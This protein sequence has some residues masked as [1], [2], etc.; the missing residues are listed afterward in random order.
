MARYL[1][2]ACR[3]CRREGLKLFLKGQRCYTEKCAIE[4]RQYAPGQHGQNRVKHSEYGTQLR[5]KQKVKR[6]YGLLERQFRGFFHKAEREK[7]ITGEELLLRLER[8]L[9]N[10]VYR[11]GFCGSR[12]E[13]RQFVLHGHFL[14]N[15]KKVTIPSYLAKA[16]DRIAVREKSRAIPRILESLEEI[17]RRGLPAWLELDRKNF[18]GT[19]KTLPAREELTFPVQEQLIVELYSK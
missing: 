15:D 11:I 17:E 2:S 19:I 5:E 10:M 12:A 9:D 14:V 8:R 4:R 7:G 18:A 13:A 16:G 6:L 1:E 3:L